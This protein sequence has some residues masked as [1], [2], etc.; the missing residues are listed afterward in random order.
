MASSRE[1][2]NLSPSAGERSLGVIDDN[3]SRLPDFF[4]AGQ[5][6]SGTT[7][8]YEILRRHPQI[9]MPPLKEPLFLASDLQRGLRWSAVR[10][11]PHT[12]NEYLGLFSEAKP[13]Q[14]VGEASPLYLWSEDAA[15]NIADLQPS[16]RIIA[17]FRE[18][19]DF[20]RSLHLQ[21][22]QS[23][24]ETVDD[25]GRA[26]ALENER[27]RGKQV[28]RRCARPRA[29]LYS[30]RVRYVE[31]LR[32]YHAVFPAEQVLVLIYD[33]FRADN[34]ATVRRVLRF[35]EV[36]DG[37]PIETLDANAT[38]RVRSR[39]LQTLL[40]SLYLGRG[41]IAGSAKA[42]IK[43]LTWKQLRRDLLTAIRQSVVYAPA[44]ASDQRLM[45][46]L[47]RTYKGEV[48]ALSEYLGRDLVSLWGYDR[49][50]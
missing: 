46:E 28:P 44:H 43:L 48:E 37:A 22:L 47:R 31:Q 26:L 3:A 23:R 20:L 10:G 50:H 8:L 1:S 18:P 24:V 42:V 41:P 16:A 6:K 29:L 12:L 4:L 25:L 35:L 15:R 13:E 40:P 30:E 38:V 34:E 45:L 7:A 21:L 32:R 14:R 33:D 39:R 27:R 2:W 19:A 5:P 36:D 17:I 49:I 11:R 9:F